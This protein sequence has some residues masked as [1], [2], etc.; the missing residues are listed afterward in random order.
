M[1]IPSASATLVAVA[2]TN[3]H[4]QGMKLLVSGLKTGKELCIGISMAN[5]KSGYHPAIKQSH[6]KDGE[7]SLKEQGFYQTKA[8]RHIRTVALQRDHYLCQLRLSEN[9]TKIA[10][11]VHHIKELEEYPELALD[12]N[13]LT[14]TCYYCHEAT[15]QQT[16]R[17][18]SGVRIIKA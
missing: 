5:R 6:K 16:G 1:V 10:T 8:W 14:S 3:A 12:I 9:C 17:A 7:R 15:K 13:N 2:V 18:P 4:V 11:T